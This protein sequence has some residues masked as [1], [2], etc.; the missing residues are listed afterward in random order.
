MS[1]SGRTPFIAALPTLLLPCRVR[2]GRCRLVS[3]APP[4]GRVVLFVAGGPDQSTFTIFQSWPSAF[5]SVVWTSWEP[6]GASAS[7]LSLFTFLI[8]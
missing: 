7:N 8:L 2:V 1:V 4:H 6:D 3:S 5:V